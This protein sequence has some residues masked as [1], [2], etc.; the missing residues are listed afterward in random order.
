MSDPAYEYKEFRYNVKSYMN[1]FR[2][3]ITN[4]EHPI[5]MIVKRFVK[6][7]TVVIKDELDY[8]Y[9]IKDT[10]PEQYKQDIKI[11]TE[12]IIKLLQKMVIML[13]TALRLMYA[14]TISY[15]CFI[16]EKDEFINLVN[17]LLLRNEGLYN[18]LYELFELFLADDIKILKNRFERLCDIRP[19]ELGIHEKF[20]LNEATVNFQ[21]KMFNKN[22][23]LNRER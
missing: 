2:E 16:E 21:R 7:I 3:H 20:C 10:N 11:K 19:E 1:I 14:R 4:I 8:L 22:S 15:N 9:K 12:K 13:Q 6:I 18:K 23:H 5:N 17:N